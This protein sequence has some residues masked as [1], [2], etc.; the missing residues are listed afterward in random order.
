MPTEPTGELGGQSA[1][2]EGSGRLLLA[3]SCVALA[4][5]VGVRYA[6]PTLDGDLFFH[7]AYARQFLDRGTLIADHGA[8]SWTPTSNAMIYCAW[9]GQLGLFALHSLGGLPLLFALRYVVIASILVLLARFAVRHRLFRG[10][11]SGSLAMAVLAAVA[12]GSLSGSIIKPEL[13]SLLLLHLFLATFT[14]LLA[15]AGTEGEVRASRRLTWLAPLLVLVWVNTH[16]AFVL[17]APFLVATWVGTRLDRHWSPG[18]GLSVASLRRLSIAWLLCAVAVL[19]TPYGWRYP[20]QLLGDLGLG[21][22]ARPDAAWNQSHRAILL[23]GDWELRYGPV[24]LVMSLALVGLLALHLGLGRGGQ[25][26]PFTAILANAAYVPLTFAFARATYW[27]PAVFGWT[28]LYLLARARSGNLVATLPVVIRRRGGA[29]VTGCA[30]AATMILAGFSIDEALRRP[31]EGSWL[32]FGIRALDPVVEA[33]YLDQ[34]LR[35]EPNDGH[36]DSPSEPVRLYNSF[37]AGSYLLW[38]LDPNYQVMTDARS[39]PYL[40][41]WDDQLRFAL[42][43]TFEDFLAK[44]PADIAVVDHRQ[45]RVQR[46]FLSS[47]AWLPVFYGPAAAIFVRRGTELPGEVQTPPPHAGLDQ[48][49][50]A[51]AA[52]RASDFALAVGDPQT[53]SELVMRVASEPALARQVPAAAIATRQQRLLDPAAAR[54]HQLARDE[55][56]RGGRNPTGTQTGLSR[57]GP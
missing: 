53:A 16:G 57:A 52:L 18:F 10:A 30:T 56:D 49:R 45:G 54:I 55:S 35:R 15:A 9:A 47:A 12:A 38:R 44:Y 7:L 48:V 26:L 11:A 34:R 41:W 37:D 46:N 8:W 50:S 40:S 28:A 29:T 14:R 20:A 5:L 21:A 3:V 33:E 25:R 4:L 51:I 24:L 1:L 22:T 31:I 42:G 6:G 27:W 36:L 19:A 39:F 17:L 13:F 2:R 43:E 23:G 32:G